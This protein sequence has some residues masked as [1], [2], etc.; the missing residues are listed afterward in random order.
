M[1]EEKNE[2]A[3]ETSKA[4]ISIKASIRTSWSLLSALKDCGRTEA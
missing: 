2:E 3:K 1:E 4:K